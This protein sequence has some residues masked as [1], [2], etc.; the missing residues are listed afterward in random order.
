[1]KLEYRVIGED[2]ARDVVTIT[3][4]SVSYETGEA[5]GVVGP[6]IDSLGYRP[7]QLLMANWTNGYVE[8]VEVG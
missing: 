3:D 1:M 4:S 2:K 5:K 8:L 7:T 6:K